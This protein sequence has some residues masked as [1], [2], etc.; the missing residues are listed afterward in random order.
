MSQAVMMAK[1]VGLDYNFDKAVVANSF[2]AH[3]L[4]H[5]SKDFGVQNAVKEDLL[6]AY[7][8]EG[9]NID[10]KA[11]LIEIAKNIGLDEQK[12][13]AFLN[14]DEQGE[15]VQNDIALAKQFGISGVPFFVFNRKYAVSGAQG[16][17]A[18][19]QALQKVD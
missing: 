6:K 13:T 16:V 9:K 17:D 11:T 15:D 14:T 4:L 7:F 12:T 18:F 5:F 19:L 8:M 3:R 2:E 10:N 1:N